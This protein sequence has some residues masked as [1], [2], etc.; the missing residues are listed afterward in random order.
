MKSLSARVMVALLVGLGVVV[1]SAPASY[2]VTT[3]LGQAATWE[4]TAGDD[5]ATGTSG[6]DVFVGLGGNDT[7]DGLGGDDL[8]CLGDG[9][10]VATGG[11]GTNHFVDGPG[12]DTYWGN[13]TDQ[14]D[15]IDFSESAGRNVYLPDGVAETEP[16]HDIHSVIGSPYDDHLVGDDHGD[17]LLGG[18]GTDY[19]FGG[20]GNDEIH[21]GADWD[22]LDG[23]TG[24]DIVTGDGAA[25]LIFSGPGDDTLVGASSVGEPTNYHDWLG[26]EYSATPVTAS[27]T[28]GTATGEGSDTIS[29]FWTVQ[30][31]DFADVITGDDGPNVL[32]GGKGDDVLDGAGGD[33]QLDGEDGHNIATF[34]SSPNGVTAD[35]FEATGDGTDTLNAIWEVI[36][37][38]HD[39]TLIGSSN[40]FY[41]V[42]GNDTFIGTAWFEHV[43]GGPGDDNFLPGEDGG[44]GEILGGPGNDTVT[45]EHFTQGVHVDLTTGTAS[46]TD[47][48]TT[49]LDV[50]EVLIGSPYDDTFVGSSG[51]DTIDTLAG[52]D[53][54]QPGEGNDQV[55]TGEGIDTISYAD[56]AQPVHAELMNG[57][58]TGDGSDT[59]LDVPEG[60]TGSRYDDVLIGSAGADTL[61]GL[62]G[63]DNLMGLDGDDTLKGLEGDDTINGGTGID[64]VDFGAATQAIVAN[65]LTWTASGEG[66]DTLYEVENVNGSS[67]AD[68]LLGD[69]FANVLV[70]RA[71]NDRMSGLGGADR[72]AGG[73]GN[74]TVDFRSALHAVNANLTQGIAT[75]EG[76]D[77]FA[78]VEKLIGSKFADT[79]IGGGIAN[80]LLGGPGADVLDGRGGRDSLFGN[81]GSDLLVGGSGI[82]ACFGGPDVDRASGCEA[83][84]SIP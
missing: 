23:A 84:G 77:R 34:A 72:F 24:D 59:L 70:G 39:D 5:T 65:L 55:S 82:D 36:G 41:G 16:L 21:G 25:D 32:R 3:C 71:G 54:V 69:G 46:A 80:F 79:L 14:A 19:I 73:V 78:S 50:P 81:S 76:S 17:L 33:D 31:S 20:S 9:N 10:D 43:E 7:V 12:W 18:G 37:S 58:V 74:D 63:D 60:L 1:V 45:Y 40:G 26:F 56:A 29:G 64:T 51:S 66:Q 53:T 44:G 48:T 83:K 49:F 38:Q 15:V 35:I 68:T 75:G 13:P 4:G 30:G 62:E 6:D 42:A 28:D 52:N 61:N 47:S 2:A 8:F 11:D 22:L 67:Y 27:L 57:V